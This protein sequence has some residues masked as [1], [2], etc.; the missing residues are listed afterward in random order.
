MP[1]AQNSTPDS[2]LFAVNCIG[3]TKVYPG[4]DGDG[5]GDTVA[6]SDVSVAIK[7]NEFFVLLGP[8]GCGKTT[9]LRCIAG[10]EALTAGRILLSGVGID[11]LPPHRRP[12]NTVFQ[13]YAL[14]PHMTVFDNI[15]FSLRM[16]KRAEREV[17]ATVARMLALV[18]M[19]AF[20]ARYPA[21]LSGGQQ[22]RV[23]LA[24]ALASQPK[25]LLLDEP[26]S[27]LDLKLRQAMRVELK[28]LQEETGVTFVLVTHDQDEALSMGERIAVLARGAIQQTG[29]PR[30]IYDAPA[31]CF[32]ADFIGESNFIDATVRAVRADSVE[33]ESVTGAALSATMAGGAGRLQPGDR[34]LL[35]VRPEKMVLRARDGDSRDGD[36][37]D[38]EVAT[39]I[40][41]AVTRAVYIGADTLYHIDTAAGALTARVQNG[42]VAADFSVGDQVTVAFKAADCR[43]LAD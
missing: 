41:G 15:A 8:S 22:Q 42:A 39:G 12:V 20:G 40:P 43:A 2:K 27:A 13:H 4:G 11:H 9:L 6:L 37:R 17:A 18:H 36:S 21:Q 1:S 16:L 30:E 32:V 10:F 34:A 5:D 14:F 25:V 28:Q 23:A 29:T 31:N 26:L 33:C 35:S 38:G 24:R 19:E 3:V 7:D